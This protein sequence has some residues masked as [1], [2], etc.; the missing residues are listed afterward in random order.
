MLLCIYI[1]A[2]LDEVVGYLNREFAQQSNNPEFIT[3]IQELKESF[4]R[5]TA[6]SCS[7]FCRSARKGEGLIIGTAPFCGGKCSEDCPNGR[8]CTIGTSSWADYGSGCWTGN[9]IC[10]C[11]KF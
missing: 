7:E 6:N 11:G 1:V 9:K 2:A 5:I 8:H 4:A 3:T 10:C